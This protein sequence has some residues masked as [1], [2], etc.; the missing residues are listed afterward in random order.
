MKYFLL[1][2]LCQLVPHPK[3]RRGY[4][5]MIGAKIGRN[6]RI[7]NV[8]FIQIQK[9][10]TNLHCEDDVFIGS[11]VILNLSERLFIGR[12]SVI[13]PDCTILTH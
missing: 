8:R 2:I 3:I 4:L 11:G 6:V 1:N 7:E 9:S 5:R 12:S 10:I 13:A